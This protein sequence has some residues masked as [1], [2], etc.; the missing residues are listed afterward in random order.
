MQNVG[1]RNMDPLEA[2]REKHHLHL[3]GRDAQGG[4]REDMPCKG[5]IFSEE[6]LMLSLG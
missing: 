2:R 5:S 6:A 4:L 1:K 3:T